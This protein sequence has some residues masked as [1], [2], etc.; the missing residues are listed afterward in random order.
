MPS[1]LIELGQQTLS[2]L[3]TDIEGGAP[4][5]RCQLLA[6]E[7]YEALKHELRKTPPAHAAKRDTLIAATIQCH[8]VATASIS[9]GAML[10]E[11]K[12]AIDLLAVDVP[13]VDVPQVDI[14]Q[15][16]IPQGD[17]PQAERPHAPARMRPTLRVIEG[18]LSRI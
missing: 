18:G 5:V 1:H 2:A 15:V 8:R 14:P 9:P 11:L 6:S 12:R 3:S 17:I 16:D 7:F 13:Q 4:L 10:D